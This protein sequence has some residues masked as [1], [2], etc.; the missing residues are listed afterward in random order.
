MK[1]ADILRFAAEVCQEYERDDLYLSLRQLYYQGVTRGAWASGDASYDRLGSVLSDARLAGEFPLHAL[2]DRGRHVYPGDFTR[3]DTKVERALER[4]AEAARTAPETYLGR[5]RWFGQPVHVSVWWEKDALAGIFEPVCEQLGV[6]MFSVRGD[7]SHAALYQWLRRAAEA[8]GVDNPD[9]WKAKAHGRVGE[10]HHKGVA[11]RSVILYFGDHDPT[12]IRIPRTAE[13]TVRTFAGHLGLSFP[14]EF[15]RVGVTLDRARELDLL[16]FPAKESA[17]ADYR[18]YVEEFGTTDA[19]ELDAVEPRRL[20][21]LVRQSVG[22]YFD[23]E[24]FNRLQADI[25]RRAV[26]M[27]VGMQAPMWHKAA[28]NFY[29][30]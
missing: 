14:I 19:W 4:A 13:A 10:D 9:G 27:R 16:P 23:P 3:C 1:K 29:E 25:T 21:E 28:T 12:G 20:A 18:R 11:R 26:E 2:V 22:S 30:D 6:S 24:L 17:G 7:A 15:V 5:A 8:H